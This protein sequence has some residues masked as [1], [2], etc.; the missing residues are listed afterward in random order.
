MSWLDYIYTI[1]SIIII[2]L[3]ILIGLWATI[4]YINFIKLCITGTDKYELELS[5]KNLIL[6]SLIIFIL[7]FLLGNLIGESK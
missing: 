2:Y 3:L 5:K 1:F 4:Y 6:I 7:M